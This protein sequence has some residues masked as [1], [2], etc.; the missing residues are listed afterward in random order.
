ML[1]YRWSTRFERRCF[2]HTKF[3]LDSMHLFCS[4]KSWLFSEFDS[5]IT[6]WMHLLFLQIHHG[7][8]KRNNNLQ[9]KSRYNQ[10]SFMGKMENFMLCRIQKKA[11][12]PM[13]TN[14]WLKINWNAHD[15]H[16]NRLQTKKVHW[17]YRNGTEHIL[18]FPNYAFCFESHSK[19][20]IV[21]IRFQPFF[22]NLLFSSRKNLNKLPSFSS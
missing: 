19:V 2:R 3:N 12:F 13:D 9:N 8:G 21:H 15:K 1:H 10:L 18:L 16:K 5:L 22:Y 17:K 4:T 14:F 7:C 6:K 11:E 20:S